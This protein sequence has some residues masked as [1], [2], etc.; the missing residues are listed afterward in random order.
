MQ[1]VGIIFYC[2][3]V[4]FS[5]SVFFFIFFNYIYIYIYEFDQAMVEA[6]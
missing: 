4:C 1:N 6:V 5:L 2:L 3:L